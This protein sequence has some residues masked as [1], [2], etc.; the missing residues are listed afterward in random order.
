[1]EYEVRPGPKA[2]PKTVPRV[3]WE[4]TKN[5]KEH[6]DVEPPEERDT[7]TRGRCRADDTDDGPRTIGQPS[8]ASRETTR[9]GLRL[10]PSRTQ[11]PRVPPWKSH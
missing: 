2:L 5:R 11:R 10:T 4:G 7:R 9:S 3:G 6:T 1:M 8:Q